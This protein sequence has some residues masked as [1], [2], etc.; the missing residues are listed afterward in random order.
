MPYYAME[1]VVEAKD[2][3]R[4]RNFVAQRLPKHGKKKIKVGPFRIQF[5]Q[6]LSVSEPWE[7]EEPK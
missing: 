6:T 5:E 1:V 3:E 7:V 4:A 2:E